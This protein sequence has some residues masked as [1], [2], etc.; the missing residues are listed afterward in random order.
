MITN[1]GNQSAVSETGNEGT[2]VDGEVVWFVYVI[3]KGGNSSAEL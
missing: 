3:A 2:I 1:K